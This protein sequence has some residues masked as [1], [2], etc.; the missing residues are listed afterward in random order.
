MPR[1]RFLHH[2][3]PLAT[4]LGPLPAMVL[5]LFTRSIPQPLAFLA[6]AVLLLLVGA[7]VAPRRALGLAVAGIAMVA[8]LTASFGFWADP[9]HAAGTTVLLWIGDYRLLEGSLLT[10]LATALR[11]TAVVAL[12]LIGGLTSSGVDLVRALV[13]HA[14]LPY[15]IGYTA[16]AAFRFVPRFR[17]ELD[18]IRAAHRVRGMTGGRGPIA[19]VRRQFSYVIPLLAGA[20]RHAER[21]AHAMDSRAF[22]AFR[23]RTERHRIPFRARDVVFIALFWLATAAILLLL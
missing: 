10:G 11:L 19:A 13:Q 5:L 12:T 2:L 18:V 22:G 3:N 17:Y 6:L 15:R 20:I 9:R 1:R 4:V 23:T 14:R 7:A 21:V 16:L 8:L